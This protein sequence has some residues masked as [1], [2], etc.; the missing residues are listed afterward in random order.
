LAGG[1]P[2]SSGGQRPNSP[3]DSGGGWSA[4]QA[5]ALLAQ[6]GTLV[7]EL[8]AITDEERKTIEGAL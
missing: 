7:Y 4:W 3:P 5:G 6:E 1:S 2:L 8:Y